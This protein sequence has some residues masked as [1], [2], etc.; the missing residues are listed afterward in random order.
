[1]P[2]QPKPNVIFVKSDP[3]DLVSCKA[4]ALGYL[5]PD[6]DLVD[7]LTKPYTLFSLVHIEILVNHF[8][9]NCRN[10]TMIYK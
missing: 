8:S 3:F 1:M 4:L 7:K 10:N 6:D 2:V 9:V 5:F